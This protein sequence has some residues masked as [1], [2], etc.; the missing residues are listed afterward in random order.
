MPWK[1]GT[2]EGGK[3]G[4]EGRAG[5]A[6][7]TVGAECPHVL[8]QRPVLPLRGEGME[9]ARGLGHGCWCV[10]GTAL[11]P[12]GTELLRQPDGPSLGR[13]FLGG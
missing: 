10:Q 2:A 7:D 9:G 3:H 1:E 11:Y 6:W 4:T 12:G 5:E 8:A 13:L